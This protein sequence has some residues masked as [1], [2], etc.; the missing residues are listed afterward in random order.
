MTSRLVTQL[1]LPLGPLLKCICLFTPLFTASSTVDKYYLFM[2]W[3]A[4]HSGLSC[5]CWVANVVIIDKLRFVVLISLTSPH[6]LYNYPMDNKVPIQCVLLSVV[7]HVVDAI[8][9]PHFNCRI[10]AL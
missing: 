9:C 5:L 6:P 1:P 7:H 2:Q 10:E 8:H 3:K 4:H